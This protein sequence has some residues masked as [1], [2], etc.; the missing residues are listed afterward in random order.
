[1]SSLLQTCC[2]TLGSLLCPIRASAASRDPACMS[3]GSWEGGVLSASTVLH[4]R[5]WALRP[6]PCTP[7]LRPGVSP[8]LRHWLAI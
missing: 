1:M 7:A 8:Q 3:S 4:S 2:L 6:C 5:P